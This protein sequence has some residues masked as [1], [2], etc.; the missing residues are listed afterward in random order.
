[1]FTT[2]RFTDVDTMVEIFDHF[3]TYGG[4]NGVYFGNNVV[5][6]GLNRG[7]FIGVDF[8]FQITPKEIVQR[9]QIARASRP[10]DRAIS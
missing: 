1:M 10:I 5:L 6:E 2:A 9:C 7:W 8:A 4:L 3:F